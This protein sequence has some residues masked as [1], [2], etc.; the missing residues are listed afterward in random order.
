MEVFLQLLLQHMNFNTAT[1]ITYIT[2]RD[3]VITEG[4]GLIIMHGTVYYF[5]S[6]YEDFCL[7]FDKQFKSHV[8]TCNNNNNNN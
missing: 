7:Q 2:I 3:A 5:D 6:D 8:K 1:G 4:R